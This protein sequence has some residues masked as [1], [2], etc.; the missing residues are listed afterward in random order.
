VD[1]DSSWWPKH[2]TWIA[3]GLEVGY[4]S[5]SCE[6]WYINRLQE[7]RNGKA[8][9]KKAS[10]WTKSIKFMKQRTSLLNSNYEAACAKFIT[11]KFGL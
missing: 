3:S 6:T 1:S 10:E 7:I 5:S 11:D 8:R 9:L 4:W 2:S